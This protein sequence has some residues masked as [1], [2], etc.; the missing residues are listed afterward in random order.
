MRKDPP[1]SRMGLYHF[2]KSTHV[3]QIWLESIMYL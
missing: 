1:E 3:K 2:D